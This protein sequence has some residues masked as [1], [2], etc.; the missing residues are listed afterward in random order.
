KCPIWMYDD[1]NV[2]LTRKDKKGREKAGRKTISI[3][4]PQAVPK[5]AYLHAETCTFFLKG[6]CKLCEKN[7]GPEAIDYEQ[8]DEECTINVGA[9]IATTGFDP[10]D[11]KKL[12]R[13]HFGDY[14]NVFTTLQFERLLNA[15]GPTEGEVV[16]RSDEKHPKKIAFLQ[17]VGS[18]DL[19]IEKEYCS[20]ACCMYAI[21]EAIM[22]KEHDPEVE[23]YIFYM[24]IRAFGKGFEE[25]YKRAINEFDIKFIKSRFYEIKEDPETHN[26]L[27]KYEDFMET[28]SINTVEMDMVVLSTGMDPT[29]HSDFLQECLHLELDKNGFV[30]TEPTKPIE[31]S[32]PGV[33][34]C[35]VAS[36]PKDIPDTV[37]QASGAAAKASILLKDARGTEVEEQKYPRPID[38]DPADEARI[39]VFVCHCGHNIASV[40]D[41]K[42]VAEYARSFPNVKYAIDPMY[43]CAADAQLLI[44]EKIKEHNLNRIIVASCTPRTHEPLFRSTLMEAG[45]NEF[46]FELTN[47]REHV[48]WVH[49]SEPVEATVK[50][51]DML[52]GAIARTCRLEPLL[53]EKIPIVQK[54]VVI[55]GGVC[56]M[57]SALDIARGGFPVYLIEKEGQLG[58]ELLN[59]PQLHNELKGE[60]IANDLIEQVNAERN[61]TIFTGA[62]IENL[63]GAVGNFTGVVNDQEIKFG[64][65]VLATGAE[66]FTPKGYYHYGED[67]R[68]MTL[69]E[70]ELNFDETDPKNVV[71]IQCVGSREDDPP[72]TYCSRICCTTAM[73]NSIRIKER[74]PD[75]N[76]FVLFKDIRTYGDI[77]ELYLKARQ[78]G[79]VFIRY[80]DE[81]KPVVSLDGDIEVLD[82]TIGELL[83]IVNIDLIL[84]STPLVPKP[85]ETLSQ[86]FKVPR[87]AD[88]FFLEAHVKLRPIDFAT[89]GVFLAGTAHYPKF[90]HES[91]YQAS[92]AAVR[93][94]SLLAPGYLLSEGAISEVDQEI[95][96]GCGRCE[97]IC[98][99]KAIELHEKVV[100]LE[101][102]TIK[103]VKAFVNP[104][105]CK[106]CGLCVVTCP[107]SAITISHFQNETIGTQVDAILMKPEPIGEQIDQ[108][109]V[110]AP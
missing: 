35:G 83:R 48:S 46:L 12:E 32:V 15:S 85:N 23:A 57:T 38:V 62:T 36:G 107:V 106:G 94:M 97:E 54:A 53:K 105:V 104:G 90:I 77:E 34:V 1:F 80:T 70:F 95:C 5:V 6:K 19:S 78:L 110:E 60:D 89:D 41:V 103:T 64:A 65:A 96:R 92:G 24:D 42:D 51:K 59:I 44:K 29:S 66:P 49:P 86:L 30:K 98:A 2:G 43:A 21:K 84:L 7:C 17:C 109:P 45:L 31:T 52:R 76:V 67:R 79:V 91:I 27:L 72:R 33:F 73:K 55:G 101:T 28:P 88:K 9:V 26:L 11:A 99:Y 10:F 102:R 40:V 14:P 93:V 58:G 100:E 63:T 37:A 20:A 3:P 61:I 13:L 87:G 75:A 74:N 18:R 4:F 81:N 56:G 50:A 8:K 82:T 68:V 71:M 47:L 22:A 108:P 16:R 25:F 69:R 39:G